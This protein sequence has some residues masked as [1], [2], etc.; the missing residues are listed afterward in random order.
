MQYLSLEAKNFGSY[1]SLSLDF[2]KLDLTLING[3]NGSGKST[4]LDMPAWCLFGVT[5]KDGK[6]DDIK[7]WFSSSEITSVI[8]NI[9]VKGKKYLVTRKRGTSQQNDFF[10]QD[11]EGQTYRGKDLIDSQRLFES[12]LG[13]TLEEYLASSYFYEFNQISRFFTLKSKEQREVLENLANLSFPIKLLDAIKIQKTDLNDIINEFDIGMAKHIGRKES[14]T[15]IVDSLTKSETLWNAEHELLLKTLTKMA[16]DG[17]QQRDDKIQ[18]LY[19]KHIKE[20]TEIRNK[21]LDLTQKRLSAGTVKVCNECGSTYLCTEIHIEGIDAKITK[22]TRL[23]EPFQYNNIAEVDHKAELEREQ[24]KGNPYIEQVLINKDK[25]ERLT[26]T[27]DSLEARHKDLKHKLVTL[28]QLSDLSYQLRKELLRKTISSIES[29]TNEF[30]VEYFDGG[31][32]IALELQDDKIDINVYKNG[33]DCPYKQL[34]KGQRCLLKLCFSVA[35]MH[36][37]SNK[38]GVHFDTLLFD[39]ALDG[40]DVEFKLKAYRLFEHLSMTHKNILVVDHSEE[41]KSLFTSKINVKLI[42]DR[43]EISFE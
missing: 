19:H 22:L 31:I 20:Q 40:M 42:E 8:M 29:N 2:S 23:L 21:I 28:N 12:I 34:S 35:I 30:L 11:E 39:E 41:L 33:Y 25:L 5:A 43:S 3:L 6:S 1:K 24:N 15:T 26:I 36:A 4:I 32:Q 17:K 13:F 27:I 18:D 37:C 14:L 38:I 16:E 10:W 9:E 7:S